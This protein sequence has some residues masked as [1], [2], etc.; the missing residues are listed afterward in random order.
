[1]SDVNQNDAPEGYFAV[2][3]CVP[4]CHGCAFVGGTE[5]TARCRS[6]GDRCFPKN[7]KDGHS[8]IFISE[9]KRKGSHD[10]AED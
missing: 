2:A 6:L 8:V 7:R 9:W 1:M 10:R 3:V 4:T 5:R